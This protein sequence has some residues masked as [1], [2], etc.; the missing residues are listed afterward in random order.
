[1]FWQYGT[2]GVFGNVP[3]QLN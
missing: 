1:L 3:E 2:T